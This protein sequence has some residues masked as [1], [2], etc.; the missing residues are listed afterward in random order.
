M[1]KLMQ[2]FPLS[3][4][5]GG[6]ESALPGATGTAYISALPLTIPERRTERQLLATHSSQQPFI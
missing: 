5:P 4:N 3:Q 6:E 1:Y 2:E